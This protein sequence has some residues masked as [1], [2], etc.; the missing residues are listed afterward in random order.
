MSNPDWREVY[1]DSFVGIRDQLKAERA[2]GRSRRPGMSSFTDAAIDRYARREAEKRVQ[3]A[4]NRH[5]A[6]E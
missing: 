5:N 1:A 2:A 3:Q 4:I 6:G